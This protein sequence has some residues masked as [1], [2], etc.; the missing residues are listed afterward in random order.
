MLRKGTSRNL[1][2]T[3]SQIRM[4]NTALRNTA[5][6]TNSNKEPQDGS[7]LTTNNFPSRS[8]DQDK[9]PSENDPTNVN[10]TGIPGIINTGSIH[11]NVPA[12]E[13][14]CV[15][16][17]KLLADASMAR[18]K[19]LKSIDMNYALQYLRSLQGDILIENHIEDPEITTYEFTDA[20]L[21]QIIKQFTEDPL[22]LKS[23]ENVFQI[24]D[25][26]EI[27]TSPIGHADAIR[28]K[29]WSDAYADKRVPLSKIVDAN[30]QFFISTEFKRNQVKLN[31]TDDDVKHWYK[32][33][34]HNRL[35]EVV[36]KLWNKHHQS[37]TSIQTAY[38]RV[39]INLNHLHITDILAE[40]KLI[41]E[42]H[43][44]QLNMG[45]ETSL[46]S[47]NQQIYIKILNDKSLK[48]NAYYQDMQWHFVNDKVNYPKETVDDWLNCFAFVRSGLRELSAKA[49]RYVTANQYQPDKTHVIDIPRKDMNKKSKRTGYG[50]NKPQ[51]SLTAFQKKKNRYNSSANCYRCGSWKH[52]HKSCDSKHP[53]C[54]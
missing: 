54:N 29:R 14:Q 1:N 11:S 40:Q 19:H 12:L 16:R 39:Q 37:S 28:Y 7:L 32:K 18:N 45:D 51:A 31:L 13:K 24:M 6:V 33:W 22:P 27:L 21:D 2:L 44:I 34:T 43:D 9:N 50:D 15:A 42:V 53:D 52:D 3:I 30:T 41:I 10:V 35:A 25:S 20:K 48:T 47:V 17:E 4:N 26:I 46:L 5:D 36:S 8:D 38:E 49:A 23:D